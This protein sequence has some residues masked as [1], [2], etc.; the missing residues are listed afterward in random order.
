MDRVCGSMPRASALRF[1]LD[2]LIIGH[3]MRFALGVRTDFPLQ[4]W[5]RRTRFTALLR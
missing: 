4:R 1:W 3:P 2:G 5:M